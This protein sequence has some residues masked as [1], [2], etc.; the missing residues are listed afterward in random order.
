[1][2]GILNQYLVRIMPIITPI[3]VMLGVFFSEWLHSFV[4]LVPWIFAFM[5]FTG[6]LGSKFTD[7]KS[8]IQNPIS[9]IVCLGLLHVLMPMLAFVTGKI[10]FMN[11]QHTIT[12]LILAFVIPTGVSS[13]I[14][15]S[16]YKGNVILTLSIILIDTM[17]APILVPSV[18]HLLIGTEIEMDGLAIMNGLI[19][20]IVIPSVFGMTLNAVTKG[21]VNSSLEPKLAPFSKLGLGAVVAIN[22]SAIAPYF[23]DINGKLIVIIGVVFILALL[24]YVIGWLVAKSLKMERGAIITVTYN[25]GMRN[26]SAAAVLAISYFPA[27]VAVPVIIGMLFQQ[28]LA[29]LAGTLLTKTYEIDEERVLSS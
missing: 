25:S 20:M 10:I 28:I 7:L 9:L 27:P 21:K 13:L 24:G 3:G 11:D 6:S 29:S 14:W 2:L 15:V 22:S 23:R 1:M 19:W 4:F 16:I 8:V 18:L 17:L 12:G 26:I 5:T